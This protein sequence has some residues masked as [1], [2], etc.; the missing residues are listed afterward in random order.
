M[1]AF[2]KWLIIIALVL[3]L[4]RKFGGFLFRRWIKNVTQR[5]GYQQYDDA[6]K[7]NN[8]KTREEGEIYISKKTPPKDSQTDGL[9]DFVDYEEL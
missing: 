1:G 2:L 5:S 9:G 3:W 7:S 6:R 8:K 4:F